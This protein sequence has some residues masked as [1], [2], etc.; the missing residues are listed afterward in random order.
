MDLKYQI[1]ELDKKILTI[2]AKNARV[3]YLEVARE[4]NVSGA[5]IHQRMQR[6][7]DNGI[8][9]G[10]ELIIDTK[11]IGYTTCSFVGVYLEK[12]ALYKDV[13]NCLEKIPEIVE[14]HYTTGAYS[15]FVKII[16][17]DNDHLKE[18]IADKLQVITG[19]ERTES[20]ISLEERIKRQVPIL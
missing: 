20:F 11:K 10:S 18:I 16:T 5:A 7:F 8:I 19:I 2:V 12:A 9:K 17:R 13:M 1:D 4:C 6:L 14:C 3:P 15:I